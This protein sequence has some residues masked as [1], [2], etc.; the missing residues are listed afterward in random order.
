MIS[1]SRWLRFSSCSCCFPSHLINGSGS[2]AAGCL[3]H[4]RH[5]LP[6]RPVQPACSPNGECY[7]L[8]GWLSLRPVQAGHGAITNCLQKRGGGHVP[9]SHPSPNRTGREGQLEPRT[10]PLRSARDI[11]RPIN[12]ETGFEDTAD[13]EP[14][15]RAGG[16]GCTSRRHPGLPWARVPFSS[17]K[18]QS[19]AGSR[20][21]HGTQPGIGIIQPGIRYC[22]AYRPNPPPPGPL[23]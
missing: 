11:D 14:C 19:V 12:S 21:R 2:G 9:R 5:G 4:S 1:W 8:L 3:G 13:R 6:R 15:Q 10:L 16:P 18:A 23:L 20:A 22:R 7:A 17:S